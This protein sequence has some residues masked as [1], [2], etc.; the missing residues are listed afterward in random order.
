M[1]KICV[2]TYCYGGEDSIFVY[3]FDESTGKLRQI[4]ASGLVDKPSYLTTG[5]NGRLYAVGETEVFQGQR[6]G[7]AAVLELHGAE[8]RLL[9]MQATRGKSPCHLVLTE[10]GRSLFVANYTSGSISVYRVNEDATVLEMVQLVEHSGSGPVLD[11]Q[12]GA[13]VHFCACFGDKLYTADLG[14]DALKA[15]RILD[16]KLIPA[17]ELDIALRKGSGVRHFVKSNLHDNLLVAVCELS[18]EVMV[19]NREKPEDGA[20]QT[21]S[22]LPENSPESFCAAIKQ[23]SDGKYILASNRGHDSIAVL[24]WVEGSTE[25]RVKDIVGCEGNFP[26][27]FLMLE[28]HVLVANQNSDDLCVFDFDPT[29]GALRFTGERVPCP[30]PV[31]AIRVD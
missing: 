25:L 20:L 12:E 24:E 29:T 3:D 14:I 1:A 6:G 10:D 13:H 7:A 19:L 27:D 22:T 23:S 21:I 15:Y 9:D 30:K 11:R 26:R 2:G 31:C 16:D 28:H 5:A 18:S 8:L 4:G 17:P